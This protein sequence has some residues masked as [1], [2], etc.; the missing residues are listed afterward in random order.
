M[1]LPPVIIELSTADAVS[2]HAAA[3]VRS[4]T[5]AVTDGQCRVGS[6]EETGARAVVIVSWNEGHDQARIEIG[7]SRD[8]K[9]RWVS[10]Q[11]SFKAA[12]PE[13]ERWRAVGLVIGTLVGERERALEQDDPASDAPRSAPTSAPS[14]PTPGRQSSSPHRGDLT[15]PAPSDSSSELWLGID[16]V[17]GPA[18]D[19]GSWRFGAGLLGVYDLPRT[20]ALFSSTLRY[21]TRPS[22]DQQVDVRWF[23]ISMGAGLHHEPLPALRLEARTEALLE[24]IEASVGGT[25]RDSDGRWYPGLRLALGA[26]ARI[27]NFVAIMAQTEVTG[28]SRGT[29][30]TLEDRAVGRAPPLTWAFTVGA[31]LRVF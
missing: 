29:V 6:T 12:D 15:A 3:L 31:R 24:R 13:A 28:V 2:V 17:L 5:E 1:P 8:G 16:A 30:I 19:D 7:V 4:C 18:L 20:P 26:G 9:N 22:D 21:L 11:L 23:G 14:A 25:R 27:G 10:R